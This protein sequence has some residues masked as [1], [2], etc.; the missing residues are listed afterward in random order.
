VDLGGLS[1][2][3]LAEAWGLD[4]D[5]IR[6]AA[7]TWSSPPDWDFARATR[8]LHIPLSTVTNVAA[9]A[10]NPTAVARSYVRI[11]TTP[12]ERRVTRQQLTYEEIADYIGVTR[13]K[14]ARFADVLSPEDCLTSEEVWGLCIALLVMDRELNYKPRRD[15]FTVIGRDANGD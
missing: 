15:Y 5:V 10:N 13:D 8:E 6:T 9:M 4:A 12:T 14:I 1:V 11:L 3:V 7:D 2:K